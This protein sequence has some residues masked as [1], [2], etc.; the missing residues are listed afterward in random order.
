M[1]YQDVGVW[2]LHGLSA[3]LGNFKELP[4]SALCH[5]N[6]DWCRMFWSNSG[7]G[8][9]GLPEEAIGCHWYGG[10]RLGRMNEWQAGPNSDYW[11]VKLANSV[12]P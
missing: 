10:D 12:F 9:Y 8:E 5:Y 1:D 6:W 7:L 2:M 3:H 4:N 11:I